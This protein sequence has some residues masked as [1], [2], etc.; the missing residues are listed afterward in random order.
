M[1]LCLKY[2]QSRCVKGNTVG[3]NRIQ[4]MKQLFE[5]DKEEL[6]LLNICGGDGGRRGYM[7]S[8]LITCFYYN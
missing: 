1:V 6:V 3:G 7:Q 2:K 4:A 5:E 8:F